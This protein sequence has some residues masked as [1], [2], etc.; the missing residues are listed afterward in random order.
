MRVLRARVLACLVVAGLLLAGI[1]GSS[2]NTS[3]VIAAK[4]H[5]QFY[6]PQIPARPLSS[7]ALPLVMP[8]GYKIVKA[9]PFN[10]PSDTQTL[11]KVA[12]PGTEVPV[13]GGV[14]TSPVGSNNPLLFANINSSYPF[15]N[16]WFVDVNTSSGSGADADFDVYAVCID[17]VASYSVVSSSLVDNPAATLTLATA[18]CPTNRVLIGGG[19]F[20]NS[21]NVAVNINADFPAGT[22]WRVVMDNSSTADASLG[23]YAICEKQ[24]SG[25]SQ[26]NSIQT[27]PSGVETPLAV[28][29]PAGSLPLSGGDFTG[30]VSGLDL[31]SSLPSSYDWVTF[32]NDGNSESWPFETIVVCAA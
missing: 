8:A 18:S 13:G 2:G 32:M 22:T 4:G 9:G 10:A 26:Q 14:L 25:Y 12:C 5:V 30:A 3:E 27:V 19:A 1:T 16:S 21:S 17:K 15:D 28:D 23:A 31:S 11:G 7:N 24:P 6:K 20:S 29:C